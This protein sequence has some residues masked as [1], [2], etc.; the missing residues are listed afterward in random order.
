MRISRR[1]TSARRLP[2]MFVGLALGTGLLVDSYR[3]WAVHLGPNCQPTFALLYFGEQSQKENAHLE[4]QAVA[5]WEQQVSR[6]YGASYA[7]FIHAKKRQSGV[8]Q[9]YPD[10]EGNPHQCAF[11]FGQPCLQTQPLSRSLWTNHWTEEAALE[12]RKGKP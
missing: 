3:A 12:G 6:K 5:A 7:R 9:C 11:A 10:L 4:R 1:A 8:Q 2:V